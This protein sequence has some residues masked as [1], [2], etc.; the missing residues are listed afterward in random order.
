MLL[1]TYLV[2]RGCACR[3]WDKVEAKRG[4]L[5][6]EQQLLPASSRKL[7]KADVRQAARATSAAETAKQS[8]GPK[9]KANL[10]NS[11]AAI[12]S[13]TA[14]S[15]KLKAGSS[16][17][18]TTPARL[19]VGGPVPP[20]P[21][22]A[23]AGKNATNARSM[24]EAATAQWS[25]LAGPSFRLKARAVVQQ[26]QVKEASASKPKAETAKNVAGIRAPGTALQSRAAATPSKQEAGKPAD[27]PVSKQPGRAEQ[28]N[29]EPAGGRL[30]AGKSPSRLESRQE[31][32]GS[33]E[34]GRAAEDLDKAT[35]SGQPASSRE[36]PSSSERHRSRLRHRSSSR[37]AVKELPG[38]PSKPRLTLR[39]FLDSGAQAVD[40]DQDLGAA[41]KA[42]VSA[43]GGA[44]ATAAQRS[45]R[46]GASRSCGLE[47]GELAQASGRSGP[48]PRE[49]A[50]EAMS[51]VSS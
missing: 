33:K 47:S 44:A 21:A 3:Q 46:Q 28:G 16:K 27:A 20:P 2:F 15:A 31:P 30:E 26:G 18:A 32:A 24:A 9:R 34:T 51:K 29:A 49:A 12:T 11:R 6:P 4:A 8:K 22:A 10:G 48:E 43:E 41:S 23:E 39:A 40:G 14:D 38:S 37:P 17:P 36:R 25:A 42:G 5:K 19:E 7:T 50:G 35:S 13:Q 1:I 45:V